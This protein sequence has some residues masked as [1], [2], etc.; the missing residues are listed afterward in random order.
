VK[1]KHRSASLVIDK[2]GSNLMIAERSTNDS[3][4]EVTEMGPFE[5]IISLITE[6]LDEYDVFV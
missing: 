1:K 4:R 5:C 6:S 2:I 3:N